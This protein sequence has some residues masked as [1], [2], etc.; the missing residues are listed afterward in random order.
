[1]PSSTTNIVISVHQLFSVV[2]NR[3]DGKE[4]SGA[5]GYSWTSGTETSVI[6]I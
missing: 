4:S 1:L 5:C 3:D 2:E 6:R